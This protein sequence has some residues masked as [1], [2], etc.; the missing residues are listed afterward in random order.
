MRSSSTYTIQEGVIRPALEIGVAQID[1]ITWR[2]HF[3]S[4]PERAFHMLTSDEGR[5]TFW[6]ES[7]VERDGSIEF[8]F[9][10]G[11]RYVGKI[12]E[13]SPPT[14]FS[15]EYFGSV[16]TFELAEDGR[17]GTDLT[18][19]DSGV[20]DEDRAETAAGWVSVLLGLKSAVDFGVDLRNHD[21][22]R[23][24]DQGFIDN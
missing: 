13:Y 16:A 3:R 20:P 17:G 1:S 19:T 4:D 24:W 8:L 11:M 9:P 2:I 22:L 10:N 12:L 21:P 6:A 15:I 23:N 7:A 18:L 14:R 5:A